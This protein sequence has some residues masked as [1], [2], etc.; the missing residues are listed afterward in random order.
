M[1]ARLITILALALLASA[2][3]AASAS[4]VCIDV[5]VYAEYAPVVRDAAA[6]WVA[7]TGNQVIVHPFPHSQLMQ[8]PAKGDM[9]VLVPSCNRSADI[10]AQKGFVAV[11]S[12]KPLFCC[13]ISVIVAPGNPRAV[14]G[15]E[16]LDRADLHW[17]KISFCAWRGED[18]LEGKEGRFIVESADADLM[19]DLLA[20]GEVDAV[21]GWDTAVAGNPLNPV[22]LRLACSRYGTPLAALIPAFVTPSSDVP[23]TAGQLVDFLSQSLTAQDIYLKQGYMLDDG[24]DARQYDTT[25]AKRFEAVYRNVVRQVIEDYGITRGK[26]LDIGCGPGQMTLALARMT[27]LDVTGLDIE[28]EAVEI[29]RR[30]AEEAGLQSRLH[31]VSADAHSL[32]FSEDTFNLIVS[33]G[34]LP[35]L[36]DQVLAVSEVYRVLKPG[37]VAFLGGGMGRLTPEEEAEKLYPSGVTPQKALDWGPGQTR[38]DSIFPFPVRSFDALMTEAGISTYRVIEEGGRWVEIRK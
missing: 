37:G 24:G 14:K 31:F 33:R 23:E 28:P 19:M 26:A 1:R 8:F 32:P 15:I 22:V 36:R 25:A 21:L 30:H 18:L 2:L 17:G 4:A 27:D 20:R 7:D 38:E 13:R 10:W 12:R 29:G 6:V 5:G 9:D 11:A 3:F 34:T 16:D 35:F